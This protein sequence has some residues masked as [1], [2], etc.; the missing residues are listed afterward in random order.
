VMERLFH[1]VFQQPL[2]PATEALASDS[3]RVL[4]HPLRAEARSTLR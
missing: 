4:K 2:Q 1:R 3:E